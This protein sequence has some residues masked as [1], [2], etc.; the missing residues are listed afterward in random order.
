MRTTRFLVLIALLEIAAQIVLSR[1]RQTQII[2]SERLVSVT[3]LPEI[4]GEVCLPETAPLSLMASVQQGDSARVASQAP[5]E[6]GGFI[7]LRS[8]HPA[9]ASRAHHPRQPSDLQ[10]SGRRREEQRNR[11]PG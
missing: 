7:S 2:G 10:R 11:A 6:F 5:H 1:T 3:P 8:Y 4:G 9:A